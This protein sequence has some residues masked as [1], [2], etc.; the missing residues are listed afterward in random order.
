VRHGLTDHLRPLGGEQRFVDL[1]LVHGGSVKRLVLMSEDEPLTDRQR[2][3]ALIPCRGREPGT[4]PVGVLDPVDVLDEPHPRGLED[5]RRVALDELEV[6]GDRPDE[7]PV[8]IDQAL[9]CL[10]I[11]GG[12][13][14][15]EPRYVKA[16]DIGADSHR[17]PD[18][19]LVEMLRWHYH[20]SRH[21]PP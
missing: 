8:L 13:P 17:I 2:P 16:G 10:R 21:R 6:P 4:H 18:G 19:S 9:P 3:Q 7:P 5:V 1:R 20:A 14:P 12:G 15:H 11:A